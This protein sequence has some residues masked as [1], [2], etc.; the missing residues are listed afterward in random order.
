MD[1]PI[2][3]ARGSANA[4]LH[5]GGEDLGSGAGHWAQ[6]NLTVLWHPFLGA[7][8]QILQETSDDQKLEWQLFVVWSLPKIANQS[9]FVNFK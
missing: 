3:K 8:L 5:G 7:K 9:W 1:L 4:D 2:L 6:Q